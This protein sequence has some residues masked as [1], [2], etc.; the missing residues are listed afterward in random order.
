M[1]K[2]D[3]NILTK[4]NKITARWRKYFIELSHG[5]EISSCTEEGQFKIYEE[6]ETDIT[7]T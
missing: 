5:T 7:E 3:G 2:K 6:E 1:H 4:G